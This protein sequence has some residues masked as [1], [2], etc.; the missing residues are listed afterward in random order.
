[1][2][3]TQDKIIPNI[4]LAAATNEISTATSSLLPANFYLSSESTLSKDLTKVY[5]S[6]NTV[7]ILK[8]PFVR[9][10]LNL[11]LHTRIKI[12]N[13]FQPTKLYPAYNRLKKL[14]NRI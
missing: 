12:F 8:N 10:Y 13:C 9:Y 1:M 6:L 7:I 14:L 2:S 11:I 4:L 3:K 5:K